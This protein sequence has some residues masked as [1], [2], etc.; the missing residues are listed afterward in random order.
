M[1]RGRLFPQP[2]HVYLASVADSIARIRESPFH[3]ACATAF[4]EYEARVEADGA[5]VLIFDARFCGLGGL[6]LTVHEKC[7]FARESWWAPRGPGRI[8]RLVKYSYNVSIAAG[9]LRRNVFR[10]DSPDESQGPATIPHHRYHHR[11]AFQ[12][13][14]GDGEIREVRERDVPSFSEVFMEAER[15]YWDN[16]ERVGDASP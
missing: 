3:E 15:W 2:I 6:A 5:A 7:R 8:L 16:K 1:P 4:A 13:T 10:Y 11:H 9:H 14:E 12:T